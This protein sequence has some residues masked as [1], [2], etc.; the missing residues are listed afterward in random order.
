LTRTKQ[1]ALNL[2]LAVAS[3]ACAYAIIELLFFRLFLPYLSLNLMTHLPDTAGVLVQNSK[4]GFVPHDYVALLGDSYAE[5][6]GDWLWQ[7]HG[8]RA[9]PYHSANVI[10]EATGRDV[11]S[12]GRAGAGSAEAVVLRPARILAGSEC[13][14]FPNIEPPRDMFIYFYE[15]N[16]IDDNAGFLSSVNSMHGN[17]DPASIDR[18]LVDDYASAS[19]WKCHTYLADTMARMGKFL[20]QYKIPVS[21]L[22][23]ESHAQSG[24]AAREH[25]PSRRHAGFCAAAERSGPALQRRSNSSGDGRSRPVARL[26]QAAVSRPADDGRLHPFAL[27]RLPFLG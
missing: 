26:A 18:F 23:A 2:L 4:S 21:I 24:L 5:G 8:N 16:D 20:F 12:F 6:V 11:V 14:L 3:T 17:T 15:G 9:K 10:H 1:F 7:A 25:S 22:C 19:P 27:V 13:Y